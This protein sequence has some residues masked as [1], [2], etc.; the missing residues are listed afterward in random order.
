MNK[1]VLFGVIAATLSACSEVPIDG[2]TRGGWDE[3]VSM[4]PTGYARDTW[5]D[6]R[7]CVYFSTATGWVPQVGGNLKQVCR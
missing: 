6:A 3:P 2:L 5:V 4:P 1:M 7:G